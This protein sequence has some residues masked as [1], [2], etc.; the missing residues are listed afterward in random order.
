MLVLGN[1]GIKDWAFV[2]KQLLF[3]INPSRYIKD[4]KIKIN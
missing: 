1:I 2:F 3:L 4:Y